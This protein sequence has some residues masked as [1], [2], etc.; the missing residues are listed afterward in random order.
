MSNYLSIQD[1]WIDKLYKKKSAKVTNY[2]NY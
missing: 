1:S 2:F